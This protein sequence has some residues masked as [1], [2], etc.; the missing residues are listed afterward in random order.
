VGNFGS[1]GRSDLPLQFDLRQ[2]ICSALIHFVFSWTNISSLFSAPVHRSCRVHL[3]SSSSSLDLQSSQLIC[4]QQPFGL[5]TRPFLFFIATMNEDE[6]RK[7]IL[8]LQME[9]LATI[10]ASST[11]TNDDAELDTDVSL[12]LYR[13]ELRI[14]EQHI[15]DRHSAQTVAQDELRQRDAIQADREAARRL[16][17]ELNPN[18]PLPELVGDSELALTASSTSENVSLDAETSPSPGPTRSPEQSALP[19]SSSPFSQRPTLSS[20]GVKRSASHL[21]TFGEP[22]SKKQATEGISP[23][24]D[25]TGARSG[26]SSQRS[27]LESTHGTPAPPDAPVKV[28]DFPASTSAGYKRPAEDDAVTTPS[29]KRQKSF[30]FQ[31]PTQ[32]TAGSASAV[33][34]PVIASEWSVPSTFELFGNPSRKIAEAPRLDQA[35]APTRGLTSRSS[36]PVEIERSNGP[37]ASTEDPEKPET[38]KVPASRQPVAPGQ[39]L[40]VEQVQSAEAECVACYK[41][42]SRVKSHR[43]SCGHLY[44]KKCVNR[45]FRKAV[46]DESLWP[47]QCCK[48]EMAI[49]DV[50]HLLREDLVPSVKARQVEMSVPVPNRTYCVSCSEFIPLERIHGRSALCYKCWDSTCSECKAIAHVGDC[51]NKLEQDKD[52][53]VL[54]ALA[55]QEGWKKCSTCKMIIEHNTGC[56]HMT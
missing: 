4:V 6:T 44:C 7:L 14:A 54:E 22:T 45:L 21:D 17:L 30:F 33:S 46:H 32:S 53:M 11:P 25:L 40:A 1:I 39:Q 55:E 50:E 28:P 2:L 24:L 12:R 3:T 52:I 10:W 42:L 41:D 51:Q 19:S 35:A 20:V 49:E 15:E 36:F 13:Q 27:H 47:P 8:S 26:F 29:A 9:D 43:N 18:E 48:A 5:C 56:N 34:E 37:D 31:E 23:A 16:F 38:R